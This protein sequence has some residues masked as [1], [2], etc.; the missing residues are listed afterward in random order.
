M[1]KPLGKTAKEGFYNYMKQKE[2]ENKDKYRVDVELVINER[3]V[4]K[5][6]ERA[7]KR[8]LEKLSK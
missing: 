3:Q 2:K 6:L 4:E 5:E 7:I 1:T 8:A